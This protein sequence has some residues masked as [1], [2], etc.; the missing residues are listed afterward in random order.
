ME[1]GDSR[2]LGVS[3]FNCGKVIIRERHVVQVR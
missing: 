3:N 1:F 2:T